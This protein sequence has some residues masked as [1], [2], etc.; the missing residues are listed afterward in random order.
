MPVSEPE[1]ISDSETLGDEASPRGQSE[2]PGRAS[3]ETESGSSA[4]VRQRIY[5][6]SE[7][8]VAEGRR[9]G[10]LAGLLAR[11]ST[12][13]VEVHDAWEDLRSLIQEIVRREV[14][15][16]EKTMSAKI[17]VVRS[18]M[19]SLRSEMQSLRSEFAAM[20]WMIGVLIA[21]VVALIALVVGSLLYSGPD[22][23]PVERS[24]GAT[25][26]MPAAG[27]S[28]QSPGIAS[29]AVLE[30]A[31][32]PAGTPAEADPSADRNAR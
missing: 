28:E 19:Q 3:P 9:R 6:P 5:E 27:V 18:E 24:R 7:L 23:L 4:A 1:R 14:R 17:D 2:E 22:G 16:L 20:R 30:K 11:I 31:D 29:G 26:Q 21:L 12:D 10:V 32:E 25:L 15:T 8:D 13:P